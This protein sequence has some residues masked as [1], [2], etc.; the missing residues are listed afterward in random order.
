MSVEKLEPLHIAVLLL[1]KSLSVLQNVNHRTIQ[2]LSNST[3]KYI[4]KYIFKFIYLSI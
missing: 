4:N 3:F 1:G 2:W